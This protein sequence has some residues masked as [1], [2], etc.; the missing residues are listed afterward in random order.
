MFQDMVSVWLT[1]K[2]IRVRRYKTAPYRRLQPSSANPMMKLYT[3]K[4]CL[5]LIILKGL[6]EVEGI[7][8]TVLNDDSGSFRTNVF[9]E[10]FTERT[11]MVSQEHYE[12]A[13]TI[14]QNFKKN[15]KKQI[16]K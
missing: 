6:F 9:S 7:P 16:R 5:H 11:I 15:L 10:S 2:S 3:P 13:L 4:S 8:I 14:V 1:K 12:K